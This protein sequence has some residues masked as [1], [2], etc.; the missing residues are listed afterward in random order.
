MSPITFVTAGLTAGAALAAIPLIIHLVMRQTPKRIVFPA[1]RLLKERQKRSKKR[2]RVRNWLL[3]LARM[4]LV[5][6]MALALARPRLYG[7]TKLGDGEV[8]TALGLVFDTSDSM[9]YLEKDKTRLRE[10]Q[11]RALEILKKLPQSSQVFVVD[12]AEAGMPAPMSPASAQKRVESLGFRPVNRPLNQAVG[13]AYRAVGPVDLPRHEVYV[14]T[15][16][17][18]SAWDLGAGRTVEGL[19]ERAKVKGGISTY[20]LRLSPKEVRDAAIAEAEP[21]SLVTTQDEPLS[22]RVK[23][24]S[25]GPDAKRVVEYYVDNVKKGDK[26]VAI[27]ANGEVDVPPFATTKLAPGLHQVRVQLKGAPDPLDFDDRRYFTVD[28][29]PPLQVLLVADQANDAFFVDNVLSV[30]NPPPYK[31]TQR[32]AVPADDLGKYA[33]IFLLNVQA[34]TDDAWSRLNKYVREGGGLVVALGDRIRAEAYN[35]PLAASLLPGE[36]VDPKGPVKFARTQIVDG[37]WTHPLLSE[38]RESMQ[39]SLADVPVFRHAAVNPRDGRAVLSFEDKSPALLE[40]VIAGPRS[41]KVLMWT[42]NLAR[43]PTDAALDP[44]HWN[45]LP[46]NWTFFELIDKTV[47]YLSGVAN[48]RLT[49][50]AGEDVALPLD[51]ARRFTS[52]TVKDPDGKVSDRLGQPA[53]NSGLTIVAPAMVG[54]WTVSAAGPDAAGPGRDFGFSVNYAKGEDQ[55]GTLA[56]AELKTLFPGKDA[57]QLAVDTAGLAAKVKQGRI[58]FEIFPWV[59][60]VILVL[61]TA[62]SMLANRF[63]KNA[64]AASAARPVAA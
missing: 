26:Q 53:G 30:G 20:V 34:P 24:R 22:I 8:P 17:A 38:Y 58:G 33:C 43:K 13:Q 2:L 1:L 61:V 35:G 18:R 41:G 21:S 63:Y 62:E 11:D 9:R 23:L 7:T 56:E 19:D 44:T 55:L 28:V 51:P 3:L 31:V 10:A 39:N 25:T 49:Y 46:D 6:L 16:L 37:V 50:E 32:L 64:P 40:R 45:D 59:M 48:R 27:P 52:F 36:V 54:P 12:S 4:L 57:F 15:D 42:T 29:Q 47:P 14:L 60:M 5:A